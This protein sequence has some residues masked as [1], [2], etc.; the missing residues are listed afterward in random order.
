MFEWS[1]DGGDSIERRKE[2]DVF[3]SKDVVGGKIFYII[4][5]G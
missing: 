1:R 3:S 4:N 2:G 5:I